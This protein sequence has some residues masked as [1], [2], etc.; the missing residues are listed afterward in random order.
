[1]RELCQYSQ[2]VFYN[3]SVSLYISP[4]ETGCNDYNFI[5]PMF[6]HNTYPISSR[7]VYALTFLRSA[8]M[9]KG[10][11]QIYALVLPRWADGKSLLSPCPYR[12]FQLSGSYCF[13]LLFANSSE[14]FVRIILFFLFCKRV[15][16]RQYLLADYNECLLFP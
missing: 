3:S 13:K 5:N 7:W 16:Q 6:I 4:S 8:F 10:T 1:M 9:D 12:L 2:N 14:H 11:G 15:N